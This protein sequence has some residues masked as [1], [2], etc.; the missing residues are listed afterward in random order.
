MGYPMRIEMKWKEDKE[1]GFECRHYNII[2]G[3]KS[4]LRFII[5]YADSDKIE[6]IKIYVARDAL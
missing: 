4:L 5:D 2:S 6:W 1:K 3:W